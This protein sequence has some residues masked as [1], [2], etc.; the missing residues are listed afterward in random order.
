MASFDSGQRCDYVHVPM[1][2]FL[3]GSC[4]V[5]TGG[6]MFADNTRSQT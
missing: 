6:S 3:A 4:Y 2:Q 1:C 5:A